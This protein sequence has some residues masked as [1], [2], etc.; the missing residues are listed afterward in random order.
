MEAI[1]Y[2]K[3]YALQDAVLQEV[4]VTEHE[5]YLTGGTCLSRFY[6][7]KRYSDDLDFFTNRSARYSFSLKSIIAALEKKFSIKTEAQSK[8][9]AR[10]ILNDQLQVDFVNDTAFHYKDIKVTESGYLIDNVENIFAN[11]LTAIIGRDSA[12]DVFDIILIAKYFNFS[13]QDILTAAQK[14]MAFA[15]EDLIVRLKEFPLAWLNEVKPI[16]PFT[17]TGKDIETVCR[18]MVEGKDNSLFVG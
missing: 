2:K 16:E 18:D 10:F 5:F 6:V 17:I 13:Y 4:F 14:K 3:L 1:D 11:K 9:F 8:D 12:K 15:I 7:A